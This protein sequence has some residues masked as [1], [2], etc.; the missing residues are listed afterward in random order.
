[1]LQKHLALFQYTHVMGLLILI[2]I[3]VTV[4]DRTSDRIRKSLI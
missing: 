4:I 3:V 2:I 1:V